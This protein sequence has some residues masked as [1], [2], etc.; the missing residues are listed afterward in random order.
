MI[1]YFK[2][3]LYRYYNTYNTLYTHMLRILCTCVTQHS[4]YIHT[5]L[6]YIVCTC[7]YIYLR[8]YVHTYN[9]V[10][11]DHLHPLVCRVEKKMS[12]F[13]LVFE[14]KLLTAPSGTFTCV[15]I[16]TIDECTHIT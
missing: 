3:L 10:Y 1:L 4:T 14:P 2:Y 9:S 7:K 5:I 13:S 12:L 8:T 6:M 11:I 16:I 15:C